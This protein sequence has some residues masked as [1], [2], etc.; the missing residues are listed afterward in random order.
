MNVFLFLA[1]ICKKT[2]KKLAYLK[3]SQAVFIISDGKTRVNIHIHT[4]ALV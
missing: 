1:Q 4:A 3:E 2:A